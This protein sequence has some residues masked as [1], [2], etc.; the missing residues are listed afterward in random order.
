MSH[1]G[2]P[3]PTYA[4]I[5]ARLRPGDILTHCYRPAPNSPVDDHG[6]VLPALI[7]ARQRGVLFDIGHGMGSF[8]WKTAR[9][10]ID[11]QFLPDT[12]SSDVHALCIDG[13]AYDQ[14]TTLSKFLALGMSLKDVIAASTINAA[15]A[16]SR[17][18]LGTLKPGSVGDASILSLDEG[19]FPL[20]DVRGEVVTAG[21]RIHARGVVV[22]GRW[23]HAN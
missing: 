10:M 14:V 12:I 5:L 7:E 13:P 4:E 2:K 20:E 17:P 18:D 21:Q 23:W 3:P 6:N 22:G 9:A 11:N 15:K 8:A 16:L 19:R 1:I